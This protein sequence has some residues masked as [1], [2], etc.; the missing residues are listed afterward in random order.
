MELE[1]TWSRVIRI[2]WSFFWRNLIC[3]VVTMLI[4]M[5]FG[6]IVGFIM[7]AMGF[8]PRVI[9]FVTGPIGLVMGLAISV[10]PLKLILGE[11]YGEFRLV[12][13]AK[14]EQPQVAPMAPQVTQ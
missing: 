14:Q 6:F 11:D 3:I 1:I 4:G 10:V 8:P 9:M 7:G 13:L 12:L 2:W 5:V